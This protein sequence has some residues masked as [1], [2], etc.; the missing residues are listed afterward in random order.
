MNVGIRK[1]LLLVGAVVF[2]DSVFFAAL[3][4][5]LPEL[6][7]DLDLSK[8]EAGALAGAYA[9]G[10]LADL[11]GALR[12]RRRRGRGADLARARVLDGGFPGPRAR[13]LGAAYAR[14][15]SRE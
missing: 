10:G 15:R 12:A 1:L 11:R 13:G 3:T 6:A 9:F 8:A 7:G 14:L 5:L 2:V 4:P